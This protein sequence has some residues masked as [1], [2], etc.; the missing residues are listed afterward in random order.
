MN[1]INK[2]IS[3]V[4]KSHGQKFVSDNLNLDSELKLLSG[5]DEQIISKNLENEDLKIAKKIIQNLSKNLELPFP[6][7]N[8][9]KFRI[10][11]LSKKLDILKYLVF[12]YKFYISSTEKLAFDYPTYL[13]IELVSA[14]NLRCPM[15]FQSDKTFTKKPYMGFMNFDLFKRII[16]EANIANIGAI[17]LASRGEPMMHPK[18]PEVLKYCSDKDNIFEIK[19]NTNG[20]YLNEINGRAIYENKV[21]IIVISADHYEKNLY[22][23]YRLN[24]KFEDVVERVKNF[25][26]LRSE[27]PNSKIEI[28]ISGVNVSGDINEEKFRDFWIQFSDNVSIGDPIERWDTYNN[29]KGRINSACPKLWDRM[30]IWFDGKVNPCD[31]D[32]KSY[33]SY[34]QVGEKTIKEIWNSESLKS[35]RHAHVNGKR[36]DIVPCDRCGVD[37]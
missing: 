37:G 2:I 17:T 19:L 34:G 7:S 4:Y 32:Y 23:K 11:K 26:K 16:D 36:L 3:P 33:L 15:C 31:E 18:F 27:Y 20:T 8:H 21:D 30:Y 6:I 22:E 35:L 13:L 1:K 5:I 24:A 14:C 25:Y 12:R 9:E 28:R 10:K 29:K